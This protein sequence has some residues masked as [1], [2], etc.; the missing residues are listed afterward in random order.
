MT[1]PP[2]S[3]SGSSQ[4]LLLTDIDRSLDTGYL[5]H[6]CCCLILNQF[7]H[8][9]N[10]GVTKHFRINVNTLQKLKRLFYNLSDDHND[11][12]V[13]V[14]IIWQRPVIKTETIKKFIS[15]P[16][17][18]V[19]NRKFGAKRVISNG[20]TNYAPRLQYLILP[21]WSKFTLKQTLT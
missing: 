12:T 13:F 16:G 4:Y 18:D 21:V 14:H 10:P 6:W 7:R 17:A 11:V 20:H 8:N 15:C 3:R 5:G 2:S 9:C 19:I 1:V